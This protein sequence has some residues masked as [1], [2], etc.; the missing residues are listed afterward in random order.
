VALT[1]SN[2]FLM[3]RSS[4]RLYYNCFAVICIESAEDNPQQAPFEPAPK[5]RPT[6]REGHKGVAPEASIF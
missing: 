2:Y 1:I 6:F 4:L 3:R 5:V